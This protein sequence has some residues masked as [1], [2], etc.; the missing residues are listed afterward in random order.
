MVCAVGRREFAGLDDLCAQNDRFG[1]FVGDLAELR[2]TTGRRAV[3]AVGAIALLWTAH[4][5]RRFPCRSRFSVRRMTKRPCEAGAENAA[6]VTEVDTGD[7]TFRQPGNSLTETDAA[8][9]GSLYSR[10]QSRHLLAIADHPDQR[11]DNH[12]VGIFRILILGNLPFRR[13]ISKGSSFGIPF[14]CFGDIPFD[15]ESLFV[16][17]GQ[18]QNGR[19]ADMVAAGR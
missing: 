8:V 16:K 10:A 13:V 4:P 1:R 9:T 3:L 11:C 6:R 17:V 12:Q 19:Q 18:G 5:C 7:I 2:A 14:K 15:A